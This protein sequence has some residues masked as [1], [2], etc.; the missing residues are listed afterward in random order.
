MTVDASEHLI[1]NFQRALVEQWEGRL[2]AAQN[3]KRE[4][5][6]AGD[7]CMAFFAENCGFMWG[8]PFYDEYLKGLP[9]P[10]LRVT[11][12]K[13]SEFVEIYEPYLLWDN[14]Q[15]TMMV[16]KMLD[17][18]EGLLA[19]E[20]S[21]PIAQMQ[22]QMLRDMQDRSAMERQVRT[23]L[24]EMWLNYT[25]IEQQPKLLTNSMFALREALIYGLGL[26]WPEAYSFPGSSRRLTKCSYVSCKDLLIDPD[27]CDPGWETA[28]WV[29]R[30]RITTCWELER[31]WNLPKGTLKEYATLSSAD[32]TIRD[33]FKQKYSWPDG[34]THDLIVWY[35]IYSRA[36]VGA[37]Q[38]GFPTSQEEL[39]D[40]LVGD[41][42]YLAIAP[43]V[44]FL[45]NAPPPLIYEESEE[46]VA[47]RFAW[48]A[49]LLNLDGRWP[50]ARLGFK[51]V[52][53]KPW[54]QPPLQSA[55][56]ELIVLNILVS[57][58]TQNAY[59][60]RRQIVAYVR[61]EAKQ[62]EE[63]LRN[64]E[65]IDGTV[66]LELSDALQKSVND[67]VQYVNAPSMNRDIWDAID[68][69]SMV[70]DKRAGLPEV[71]YSI[72][73]VASRSAADVHSKQENASIRPEKMSRDVAA[74][75]TEA[76]ELERLVAAMEITG[77]D[78]RGLDPLAAVLWDQY[79]T[80][81]D[82]EEIAREM[83]ATIQAENLRKP[84]RER[85]LE[86]LKDMM[87]WL[88]PSLAQLA[89][90]RGDEEGVRPFNAFLQAV[91]RALQQDVSE[92]ML[93]P[94]APPPDP[95]AAQ[96][97]QLMGQAEV[98]KTSA[99]AQAKRADAEKK[100][101][102]AAAVGMEGE[103]QREKIALD[104]AEKQQQFQWDQIKHVADMARSQQ[105]HQQKMRQKQAEFIQRSFQM[106]Q[107]AELKRKMQAATNGKA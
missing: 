78:V 36:G 68:Y 57:A 79:I 31:L 41:F 17:V 62:I 84:N 55:I 24:W 28:T 35:E 1:V 48:P 63:K 89:M 83:S 27:C 14:P 65:D 6:K 77:D 42:A 39:Y 10:G 107:E 16:R 56:G 92:W 94:F 51:W 67:L 29:A 33:R 90:T 58:A 7:Q 64:N 22:S 98:E 106:R 20:Q 38:I 15:R 75:Q 9:K 105:E 74:W 23:A 45:L 71:M 53:G 46:E 93:P 59:A 11:I 69:M 43:G 80:N 97:Q 86:N 102:E 40:D 44:P 26:L 73:R 32:Q 91:G 12:N 96:L 88:L 3:S 37:R 50:C 18:P 70:F 76:A 87:G 21:D 19:G 5:N 85:E 52:P 95:M 101:A 103:A 4:F 8:G 49:P 25:A 60:N 61:S 99:E 100:L 82:P 66:F 81:A 34:K 47:D 72:S 13:T 30:R 104:R 2:S 54:P